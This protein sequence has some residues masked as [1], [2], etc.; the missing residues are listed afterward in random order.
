[1]PKKDEQGFW[2]DSRGNAV[3]PDHIDPAVKRR[4]R[5][6]EAVVKGA[7]RL[8]KKMIAEKK[9]FLKRIKDHEKYLEKK[10]K[11]KFT[12]K[13]N[14]QRQ[15]YAG[16]MRIEFEIADRI[17]FDDRIHLAKAKIDECLKDWGRDADPNLQTI[18]K[19]AFN[20]DKRGRV[21]VK[22]IMRLTTYK[23][24][25]PRWKEAMALIEVSKMIVGSK[26]YLRFSVKNESG[27][28]ETINLN[29]S[30]L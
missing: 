9:R 13:G 25:D 22:E 29:F 10:Y 18:I 30:T 23:I 26:P 7:L 28:W 24:K 16:D 21:N 8:Q 20:V 14:V 11:T 1:M 2:I 4:D 6:V 27:V 5:D 17:E 3:N 15:N 19:N 12:K